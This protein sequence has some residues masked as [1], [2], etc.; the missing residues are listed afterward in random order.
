MRKIST[1]HTNKNV[2]RE[3]P[4][5]WR[6][7]MLNPSGVQCPAPSSTHRRNDKVSYWPTRRKAPPREM[8]IGDLSEIYS[9]QCWTSTSVGSQACEVVFL[10][11]FLGFGFQII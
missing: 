6:G 2:A 9:A 3:T 11:V 4:S 5:G 8:R 10:G 1:D 7:G